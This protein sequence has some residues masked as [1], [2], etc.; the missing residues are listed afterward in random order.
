MPDT[1]PYLTLI[2]TDVDH[3]DE[4]GAL[5]TRIIDLQDLLTLVEASRG[6]GGTIRNLLRQCLEDCRG[7]LSVVE[8]QAST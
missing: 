8:Q 6:E 5:R 2:A 4:A 1:A 7:R 3:R